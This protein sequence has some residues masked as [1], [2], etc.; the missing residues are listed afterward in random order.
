MDVLWKNKKFL[1]NE[2]PKRNLSQK[3]KYIKQYTRIA[4]ETAPTKL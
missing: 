3:I 2:L 1:F 4:A